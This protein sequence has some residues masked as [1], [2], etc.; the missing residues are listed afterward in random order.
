VSTTISA[1]NT[2]VDLA[3]TYTIS[4]LQHFDSPGNGQLRHIG[5]TPR[6]YK[7]TAEMIIDGPSNDVVDLKIVKWDDSASGFVDV[8]TQ[9]RQVN[10][11]SG[12]RNVAFFTVIANTTLDQNDFIK[13][14]VA[15]QTSTGNLTAELA[16]TFFVE[17]R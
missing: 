4:D 17:R 5:N 11:L 16:S 14:Q 3:G 9:P 15:N 8:F 13:I 7:I 12:A 1:T 2:F 6:S 10:S